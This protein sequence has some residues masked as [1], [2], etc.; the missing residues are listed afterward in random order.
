MT[1]RTVACTRCRTPIPFDFYDGTFHMC[2]TCEASIAIDVFPALTRPPIVASGEPIIEGESSCFYHPQKKAVI[3]CE[4]CGRF[5]CALCDIE[6]SG[7]HR[8][9]GCLEAGKRKE[10][11]T[12]L[13]T[14]HIRYDRIALALTTFGILIWPITAITAPAALFLVI[15]FWNRRSK[16][17]SRYRIAYVVA[18]LLALAEIC[19]WLV[20]VYMIFHNAGRSHGSHAS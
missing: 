20:L 8:C 4:S 7:V 18:G 1:V 12:V 3:A 14:Q 17:L 11:L 10:E 5:L 2:P 15:R 9:P 13:Q 16:I 6:M 19:G